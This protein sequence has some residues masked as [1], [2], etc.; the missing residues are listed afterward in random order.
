[1]IFMVCI[2]ALCAACTPSTNGGD[3]PPVTPPQDNSIKILAIGNS[4]SVDAMEY[5]YGILEDMGYEEIT[6]GNLYIGGC[7]LQTHATNFSGN[8]A[9]YTYYKNTTGEWTNTSGYE[10]LNALTDAEWDY[11]TMQQVSG[12]SGVSSSY[13]PYLSELIAIVCSLCPDAELLWHMTWAYESTS[14]H[15]DFKNYSSDQMTMYNA[16]VNTVQSVVL[17]KGT[18]T[19]VIPSGTAVQNLRT[20][21]MGDNLTRDGYHMSHD[22]GRFV[23]AMTFAKAV[24]GCS[25]STVEYTPKGYTYSDKDIAAMKEAAENACASPYSVTESTYPPEPVVEDPTTDYTQL[26]EIL[27]ANGY[28]PE[29][30]EALDLELIKFAYYNS[31]ENASDPDKIYMASTATGTTYKKFVATK[32][33]AKDQIPN[34]SLIVVKD[35]YQYRPE[36]WV[37]LEELNASSVRPGNV[38]TPIVVVNDSWWGNWNY[39][40]FNLA[41]K[42]GSVLNETTVEEVCKSFAVFVRK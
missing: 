26:E 10:P 23:T 29:E 8:L 37:S 40:A 41:V 36:G 27:V 19:K 3:T 13:E 1:M 31:T 28:D 12:N 16:I 9:K 18:F 24:T 35:G 11:I 33:F 2:A 42:G 5:L 30:Y 14:T 20:S 21:Y 25:L 38:T 15:G 22:R 34:G 39:R 7:S 32:I 6:L 17:P 4:F